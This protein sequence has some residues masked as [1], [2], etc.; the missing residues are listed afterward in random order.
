MVASHSHYLTFV[1]LDRD[2]KGNGE[3]VVVI[4]EPVIYMMHAK[5]ENYYHTQIELMS[6]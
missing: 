3:N 5:T 4:D 6:R 1:Q 2:F